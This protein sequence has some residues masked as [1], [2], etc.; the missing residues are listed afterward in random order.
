MSDEGEPNW[1]E[2]EAQAAATDEW[3][4]RER[5]RVAMLLASPAGIAWRKRQIDEDHL[6]FIKEAAQRLARQKA[7]EAEWPQWFKVVALANELPL[8]IVV[9]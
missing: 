4:R 9:E 2:L 1:R 8:E 3:N 6:W 5:E 7:H